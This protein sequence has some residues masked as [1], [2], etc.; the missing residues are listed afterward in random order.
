MMSFP[1]R[2]YR[3]RLRFSLATLLIL[4]TLCATLF[5]YIASRRTYNERRAAACF[6]LTFD[7]GI[8]F[9]DT[10]DES[11]V[12]GIPQPSPQSW[13]AKALKEG[14]IPPVDRIFILSIG[15]KDIGD[16]EISQL[17]LFPEITR[18]DIYE[19]DTITDEG[20]QVVRH[21]P[22]LKEIVLN[23]LKNVKG[24]FLRHA[25]PLEQL[26]L[27]IALDPTYL[28]ALQRQTKLK[29][30]TLSN[31]NARDVD[32]NFLADCPKLRTLTLA[33]V[34]IDGS[35]FRK[36]PDSPA[37]ETLQLCGVPLTDANAADLGRFENLTRLSLSGTPITGEFLASASWPKLKNLTMSGVRL[38]DQG[39]ENLASLRGPTHICYPSNWSVLDFRRYNTSEPPK[40]WSINPIH[41][42]EALK[43]SFEVKGYYPLEGLFTPIDRCPADLMAPVIR[44]Q[45]LTR[46]EMKKL[47]IAERK[48]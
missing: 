43:H 5:G 41:F 10:K 18:L 15:N 17:A 21:L 24:S 45:E 23:D 4:L 29:D 37:L 32:L 2:L 16:A 6:E 7:R 36:F 14:S 40:Q 39:K 27:H 47:E 34:P 19:S 3:P 28:P 8:I 38:S 13:W 31:A 33:G 12:P 11:I 42:K 25:P 46:Q 22:H 44:L 9:Y 26:Q 30:F 1:K 20:L 35:L 48:R